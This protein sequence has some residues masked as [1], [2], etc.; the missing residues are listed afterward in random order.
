MLL[1]AY[2]DAA[3]ECVVNVSSQIADDRVAGERV[4][5]FDLRGEVELNEGAVVA[6]IF[7]LDIQPH[8]ALNSL[9]SCTLRD[10]RFLPSG[11][12]SAWYSARSL[13]FQ[14]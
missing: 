3:T 10:G 8:E 2:G 14:M 7:D 12:D 13:A 4:C 11:V 6:G 9:L 5:A 1:I